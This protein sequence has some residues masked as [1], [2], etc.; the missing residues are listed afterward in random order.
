M[1]EVKL[2]VSSGERSVEIAL[3]QFMDRLTGATA[4]SGLCDALAGVVQAFGF[5]RFAYLGFGDRVDLRHPT[6]LTTYPEDWTKHYL[7]RCY[8]EIDPV[9]ER[10]RAGQGPFVWDCADERRRLSDEQRRMYA[11]AMDAGIG[12]G[13][14]VPISD[15]RG[16][17]AAVTFASDLPPARFRREIERRQHL[18][19]LIAIY[20]HTHARQKLESVIDF[21]RPHLSPRETAC[22]QWIARGKTAWEVAEVIGIS[23][24]T[25]VFHLENAKRK[26]GAVTLPQAV[27]LALHRN[28]M[29]L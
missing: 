22:L 25:V 11:E 17:V 21:D 10:A 20:F 1:E 15:G 28:V 9:V 8:Q 5:T 6:Y 27:A 4:A 24:R 7:G 2:E 29:L 3:Q 23:R 19:Q 12:C 16:R 13:F 26:L 18:L 14:T